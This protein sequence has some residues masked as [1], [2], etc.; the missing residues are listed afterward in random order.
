MI[1]HS[2]II[3]ECCLNNLSSKSNSE[4]LDFFLNHFIDDYFTAQEVMIYYTKLSPT[5]I[6]KIIAEW[7][8]KLC[9]K[10]AK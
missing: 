1:D 3:Q 7:K 9:Q 10:N 6:N 8:K 2:R 5:R 4:I